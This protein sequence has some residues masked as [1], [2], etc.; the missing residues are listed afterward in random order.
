M[1]QGSGCIAGFLSRQILSWQ[2]ED[3]ILAMSLWQLEDEELSRFAGDDRVGVIQPDRVLWHCLMLVSSK[4]L[5][6]Q[7]AITNAP[8]HNE[9]QTGPGNRT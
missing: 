1:I 4:E 2:K 9:S 5:K 8:S 6:R 3:D 7:R